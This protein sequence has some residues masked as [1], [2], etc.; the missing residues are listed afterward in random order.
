MKKIFKKGLIVLLVS[1]IIFPPNSFLAFAQ[2]KQTL[3]TQK[4]IFY[5]NE[6]RAQHN[7]PPLKENPLLSQA[8]FAKN[9]DM[10]Q[11]QYFDHIAPSGK[12]WFAFILESG[13]RPEVAGENLAKG[14]QD[15][16]ELVEAFMNS[17]SHRENILNAKFEEIGIS[18][19][20]ND[21]FVTIYFARKEASFILSNDLQQG[22]ISYLHAF[23]EKVIQTSFY[24]LLYK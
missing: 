20:G 11:N 7:L 12:K 19:V 9:S 8:A 23:I 18:V 22:F 21:N 3:N 6:N 13:Y 2:N 14:F 15:E 10:L 17:P 1:F 5:I 16:K 4:I 24:L